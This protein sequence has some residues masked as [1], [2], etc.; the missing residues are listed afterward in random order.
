[1]GTETN[2]NLDD[3]DDVV[4]DEDLANGCDNNDDDYNSHA[5]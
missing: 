5:D 2:A 1:M 4:W 3:Y